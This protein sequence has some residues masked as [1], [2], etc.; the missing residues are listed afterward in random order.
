M[1]KIVGEENGRRKWA[2]KMGEDG[3]DRTKKESRCVDGGMFANHGTDITYSFLSNC[4][5]SNCRVGVIKLV[6]LEYILDR[7]F[8]LQCSKYVFNRFRSEIGS[9]CSSMY[10]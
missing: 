3:S 8:A 7:T 6:S 4:A 9:W 5:T 1:A 2:K 10:R